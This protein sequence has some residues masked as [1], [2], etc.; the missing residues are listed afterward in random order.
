MNQPRPLEVGQER[1]GI[2][3]TISYVGVARARD[4]RLDVA[5]AVHSKGKLILCTGFDSHAVL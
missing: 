2:V 1:R 4:L 3:L 5:L